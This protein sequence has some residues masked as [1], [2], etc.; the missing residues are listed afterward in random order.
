MAPTFAVNMKETPVKTENDTLYYDKAVTPEFIVN[1]AESFKDKAGKIDYSYT[2][3]KA[4]VDITD[5]SEDG[6]VHTFKAPELTDGTYTITFKYTDG[7][8]NIMKSDSEKLTGGIY[9]SQTIVVDTKMPIISNIDITDNCKAGCKDGDVYY[10]DGQGITFNF[11]VT[12]RMWHQKIS[13]S[14][15]RMKMVMNRSL[16]TLQKKILKLMEKQCGTVNVL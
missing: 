5:I 1:E 4:G 9:M 13:K 12:V 10:M 15:L 8:G 14:L 16:Q 6:S 7:A 2:V 3:N 11:T